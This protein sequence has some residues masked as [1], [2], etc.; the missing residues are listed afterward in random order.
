[1]AKAVSV[2]FLRALKN[3]MPDYCFTWTQ[4][5]KRMTALTDTIERPFPMGKAPR[6][7]KVGRRLY[8][9]DIPSEWRGKPHIACNIWPRKSDTLG[10]LHSQTGEAAAHLA[11]QG[12]PTNF[13]NDGTGRCIVNDQKHENAIGEVLGIHQRNAGYGQ[14][15]GP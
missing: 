14:R 4:R 3:V 5:R 8:L 15:P 6:T 7:V 9:R 10:V 1:M 13:T 12:V 2:P 11:S